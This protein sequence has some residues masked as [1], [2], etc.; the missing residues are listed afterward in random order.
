MKLFLGLS[1]NLLNQNKHFKLS[2]YVI[3]MHIKIWKKKFA[4]EK[5]A[6]EKFSPSSWINAISIQI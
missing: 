5:F 3:R 4:T 6:T 2:P 1:P